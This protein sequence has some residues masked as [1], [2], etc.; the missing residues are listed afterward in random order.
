MVEK[1][2]EISTGNAT[3]LVSPKMLTLTNSTGLSG[4]K[5]IRASFLFDP[6][7]LSLTDFFSENKNTQIIKMANEPGIVTVNIQYK[8]PQDVPPDTKILRI[9][10]EKKGDA[11]TVVNLAETQFVTDNG[12]YNLSNESTEF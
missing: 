4:V 3:K 1:S 9:D 12:T 10:Y 5:E 6:N 11:K 8:N 2:V 7:V